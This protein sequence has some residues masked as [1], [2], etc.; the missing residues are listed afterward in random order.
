MTPDLE[1]FLEL[2]TRPLEGHPQ[3][4]DEAKGE[5]M[6]RVGHVGVPFEMLDLDASLGDLETA[7]PQRPWPRRIALLASLAITIGTVLTSTTILAYEAALMFM[8]NDGSLR[9][10]VDWGSSSGNPLLQQFV[11]RKA[12][13]LPLG[14]EILAGNDDLAEPA[15]WLARH[16]D[17]LA[18]WQEHATRQI[19]RAGKEWPAFDEDTNEKIAGLD[20]DN[21]L[22]PLMQASAMMESCSDAMKVRGRS[23]TASGADQAKFQ[24]ALLSFS[25][26]AAKPRY[27]DRSL[28]LVRRQIDAF[29]AARSMSDDL[30]AQGFAGFVSRPFNSYRYYGYS[31]AVMA[32]T[33]CDRLVA[34]DDRDGLLSFFREWKNVVR[35]V[36]ESPEPVERY[37]GPILPQLTAMGEVLS[38]SFDQLGMA[39]EKAQVQEQL[40]RFQVGSY[41]HVPM[42]PEVQRFA[43]VRLESYDRACPKSG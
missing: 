23:G 42:P 17:D 31:F 10:G 3:M 39:A 32:K 13:G 9:R 40:K 8:A 41:G 43:G 11:N 28:S 15:L 4:R 21:A 38:R 33:H 30:I 26:A 22:W 1:R 25:E 29:P 20:A 6:A 37:R 5:L 34:A 24:H 27:S 16:P 7:P 12:P 18:M 19:E 2:A 35:L 14:R 36:L